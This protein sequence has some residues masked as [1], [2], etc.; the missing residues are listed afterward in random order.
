MKR[1]ALALVLISLVFASYSFAQCETSSGGNLGDQIKSYLNAG[2]KLETRVID[3]EYGAYTLAI[4]NGADAMLFSNADSR[5]VTDPVLVY[6][7]LKSEYLAENKVAVDSQTLIG[8]MDAFNASRNP[9]QA[10]CEQYTGTGTHECT[11]FASCRYACLSVPLC[12]GS[13]EGQGDNFI[14]AINSWRTKNSEIDKAIS[15]FK[16]A[17]A[18]IAQ[19]P[20]QAN[21]ANSYLTA[22]EE[23]ATEIQGNKLFTC[24]SGGYCFCYQI[25]FSFTK[26]NEEKDAL[27]QIKTVLAKLPDIEKKGNIIAAITEQRISAKK[28]SDVVCQYQEKLAKVRAN[29]TGTKAQV[30]ALLTLVTSPTL[31]E[32]MAL[33]QNLTDEMVLLG[34]SKNYSGAVSLGDSYLSIAK[35]TTVHATRLIQN[36]TRMNDSLNSVKAR[37][38]NDINLTGVGDYFVKEYTDIRVELESVSALANPPAQESSLLVIERNLTALNSR[39]AT[40]EASGKRALELLEK[41]EIARTNFTR[42]S[43]SVEDYKQNYDLSEVNESIESAISN[44][45]LARFSQADE[46][47]KTAYEKT[48]AYEAS[49]AEIIPIIET[50]KE[51]YGRASVYLDERKGASFIFLGINAKRAGDICKSASDSIY[52]SPRDSVQFS[53][54]CKNAVDSELQGLEYKKY[55]LIVVAIIVLYLLYRWARKREWAFVVG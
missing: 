38:E 24:D 53:Q 55:G 16:D 35:E 26:L 51:E 36:Y 23:K 33:L 6:A 22:I 27:A 8:D 11:D 42:L 50:A 34:D 21:S 4:I 39:L 3:T 15:A 46:S 37:L 31:S 45:K 40:L 54:E 2:D 32:K 10:T 5:A 9:Q 48:T 47:L 18:G 25:N 41:A 7:V 28:A 30:N 12:R 13:F 44:A 19:N 17:A 29:L 52:T 49:L 43:K 20:E 1:L 14:Y